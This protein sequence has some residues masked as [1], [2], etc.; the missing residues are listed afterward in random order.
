[1]TSV[2]SLRG[3]VPGLAEL[4]SGTRRTDSWSRHGETVVALLRNADEIDALAVVRRLGLDG[5]PGLEIH[6]DLARPYDLLRY[7]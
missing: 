7:A 6:V 2:L 5:R 4:R 3:A 1:V